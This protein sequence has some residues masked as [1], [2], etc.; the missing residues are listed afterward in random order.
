MDYKDYYR[1]LG[2]DK[3][4]SEK[5]IKQAYRRLARKYHPDV[6]PGDKKTQETFKEINEAYEVLGD[7]DKRKK[8]DQLGASWHEWQRRGGR[9]QDFDWSQWAAGPHGGGPYVR[10]GTME[11]L[12]D[13]L[14]DL[15]GFSEFFASLFGDLNRGPG[16]RTH[17]SGARYAQDLEQSVE[18]TLEEAFHG[19]TRVLEKEG[20]RLEVKIPPGVDTGSR[21]RIA[22]E[23]MPGP[24][25]KAGGDLYLKVQ[26]VP[27]HLVERKGDDLYCDVQV[28]LYTALL[29]GEVKVPTPKGQVVLKV[30]PETHN[31][32]TFR[33]KGQGMPNLHDRSR[34]GDL[35][36]RVQVK[37]P[38]RLS[39]RERELFRE[40][41]RLR[42]GEL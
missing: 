31:G 25:G 42:Q 1:I 29:G 24:G 14:G 26:V 30:P 16:T 27:H 38:E 19:T 32:Q 35:Y 21:V 18:I 34:R 36:A 9:P 15:G 12:E 3:K 41:A 7:A 37:L 13:L 10:Y 28:N 4:A 17:R 6:N 40:L 11:D 23:G 33:L 2:V 39:E 20:R 22:G 5:D 8:Y